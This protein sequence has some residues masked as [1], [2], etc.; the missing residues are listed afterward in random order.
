MITENGSVLKT[1]QS[2][3]FWDATEQH[4]VNAGQL[5]AGHRLLVHDDKRLEGDGTGTGMG[6]DG[7]GRQVTVTAV[8]NFT[9]NQRMHDLTVADI[10]TYY[11]IAGDTPVLVHNNNGCLEGKR[12]YDVYDPESGDRITDIDHIEGGVLWEEKSAIFGDESWLNKHV[13]RKVDACLRARQNLPGY[14]N[15]PIG[16]RFTNPAK[17]RASGLPWRITSLDCGE[18]DQNLIHDWRSLS[19]LL[20]YSLRG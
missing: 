17:T 4:W 9:G 18:V 8:H 12:D 14:E 19:E 1:T 5:K 20:L 7:L 3:P 11:V 13:N 15:A 16:F 6:G 10:H 2:R